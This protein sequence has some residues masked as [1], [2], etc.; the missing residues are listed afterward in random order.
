LEANHLK[1]LLA[2]K[3]F[4]CSL[5][6]CSLELV[7]RRRPRTAEGCPQERL[8]STPGRRAER[9]SRLYSTCPSFLRV[10][11]YLSSQWKWI[12]CHWDFLGN[13]NFDIFSF[14]S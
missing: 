10:Q 14:I 7:E 6:S 4:F 2:K 12:C 9:E 13:F 1:R 11:S 8:S 3:H 5:V